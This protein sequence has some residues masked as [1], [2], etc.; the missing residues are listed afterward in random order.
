LPHGFYSDGFDGLQIFPVERNSESSFDYDSYAHG[1]RL[2]LIF[3]DL[4][5]RDDLLPGKAISG[6][7]AT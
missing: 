6:Y 1:F 5:K 4:K 3:F 7:P 2:S